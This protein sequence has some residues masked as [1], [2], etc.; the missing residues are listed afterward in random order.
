[1]THGTH[2]RKQN[3]HRL[4]ALCPY[5]AMFPPS[6][7]A[8]LLNTYTNPGDVVLD[9]FSGRGT[10]LLES[11]LSDRDAICADINPVA[12]C[13]S[14]AKADVPTVSALTRELTLL[15]ENYDDDQSELSRLEAKR[16]PTFFGFAFHPE[17]LLQI[18]YLRR[19]LDWTK[20]KVHR[21]IAAV[22]LGHLHGELNRSPN[23]LSNQMPHTISTKPDYSVRYWKT[24]GLIAPKRNAFDLLKDRIKFRLESGAPG[25][26]DIAV[27]CDARALGSRLYRR[28]DSVRAIIT[29]PPYLDVTK[30][31]E[32]QWLRLWFLGGAPKPTYGEVSS[33]DRHT[34]AEGYWRFLGEVW[35]GIAPL[36]RTD[37]HL[38]CRIGTRAIRP[39][40]LADAIVASV[41]EAWPTSELKKT[42]R[43]EIKG[44]QSAIFN[45]VASGCRYEI[46]FTFAV[47][48]RR[49]KH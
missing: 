36:L 34:N 38:I 9:P 43:S 15:T 48:A 5:F 25:R 28:H 10:T 42:H 44:S 13:V 3:P 11:L 32:D 47:S 26:K 17:T 14:A 46:D 31:E 21:F 30:F 7:V 40:E 45:P 22:V 19:E 39:S 41:R 12:Y 49:S 18:L 35:R 24:N 20:S 37:G 8:R 23:Y 1:M 16:L 4:H 29:S 27:Q 6:F 33:D 2:S